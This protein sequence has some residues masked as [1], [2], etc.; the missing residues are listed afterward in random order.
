MARTSFAAWPC[1]MARTF[2]L[3]GEAWTLLILRD[4]FFFGANRF[5]DF[6]DGLAIPTNVLTNRLGR[7]VEE[8]ILVKEYAPVGRSQH[9]Y[10]PTSKGAE[11]WTVL[12][13]MLAWGNRWET[14]AELREQPLLHRGCGASVFGDR[15]SRCG[16]RLELADVELDP[17][18]F[19]AIA[20]DQL[21]RYGK[22]SFRQAR[23]IERAERMLRK[24]ARAGYLEPDTL[25]TE[26]RTRGMTKAGLRAVETLVAA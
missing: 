11:L 26:L 19:I 7:L 8:G 1:P 15:C 22:D 2:D 17:A 6:E 9:Q 4:A 5:A 20:I 21:M 16:G 10:L 23:D 3:V 24:M 12:A 18:V 13:S 25:V 14:D